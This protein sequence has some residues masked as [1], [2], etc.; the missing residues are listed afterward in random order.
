MTDFGRE[1]FTKV[2]ALGHV[3][4]G[5]TTG[6]LVDVAQTNTPDIRSASR[7]RNQERIST[8]SLR[9]TAI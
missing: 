2:T 3:A 5:A 8:I 4:R 7:Q 6:G 9:S 1:S